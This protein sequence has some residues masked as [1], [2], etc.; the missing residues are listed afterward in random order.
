MY[1]QG[2]IAESVREVITCKRMLQLRVRPLAYTELINAL[3][4]REPVYREEDE[5]YAQWLQKTPL[6]KRRQRMEEMMEQAKLE[7]EKNA[8]K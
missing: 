7:Q 8:N 5:A 2:S 3:S 1:S 4:L 6:G